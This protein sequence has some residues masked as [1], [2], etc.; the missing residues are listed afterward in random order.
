MERVLPAIGTLTPNEEGER[1]GL[2]ML[3][4]EDPA[5]RRGEQQ[6]YR[7][8][9][10][11]YFAICEE[12]ERATWQ[13]NVFQGYQIIGYLLTLIL[14]FME[15]EDSLGDRQLIRN[16]QQVLAAIFLME[17]VLHLFV[18]VEDPR[19]EERYPRQ[20]NTDCPLLSV[21]LAEACTPM[22]ILD[23]FTIFSLL[24]LTTNR[25]NGLSSL[26]V[27]RVLS[28]YKI[29]RV[30]HVFKPLKNVLFEKRNEL[31]ST[32]SISMALLF[33]ASTAMFCLESPRYGGSNPEFSSIWKSVWWATAALTTVGYGDIVPVTVL[34]RI[35]GSI[36]A[37]IGVGLFALPAGIVAS[38]FQ[39][40]FQLKRGNR[41]TTRN[42]T[43]ERLG[44]LEVEVA[45][46]RSDITKLLEHLEKTR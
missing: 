19:L 42:T 20:L 1:E 2:N 39:E 23:L 6:T 12:H 31:F 25:L 13:S 30:F 44:R 15:M 3:E 24:P 40:A 34:G 14:F 33:V 27:L 4:M 7:Q 9:L 26:R 8:R 35:L 11:L 28:F 22:M 10:W 41:L 43:E 16:L 5:S 38:G 37:F 36:V 45:G 32:F 21:R 29:E 18:V 17:Y 46:L